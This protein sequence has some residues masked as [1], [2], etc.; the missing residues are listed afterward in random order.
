MSASG[1]QQAL[2]PQSHEDLQTGARGLQRRLGVTARAAAWQHSAA[3]ATG[4][5]IRLLGSQNCP[6]GSSGYYF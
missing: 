2:T 4:W 1:A 5:S 3:C 6:I